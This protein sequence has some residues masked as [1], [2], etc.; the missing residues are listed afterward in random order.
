MGGGAAPAR[1]GAEASP[2]VGGGRSDPAAIAALRSRLAALGGLAA[3][4][5]PAAPRPRPSPRA[6]PAARAAALGFVEVEGTLLRRAR[7]DLT[8]FLSRA[9]APGPARPEDLVRLLFRLPAG[10]PAGPF[11]PSDLAVLDIETL[12]LRGSG[13]VP[14]LV[15]V[16]VPRGGELEIDQWLLA[17][18]E[19]EAA[20]LDA[21]AARLGGRRVLVTYNGR[22]FD[23]PVLQARCILNRRPPEA[24]QPPL[25][26]DLLGPVRRLFRD[27]L[28]SCTL[29]QAELSLLGLDRGDDLPGAEAPARFRAWLEGAPASVLEGVVRHNQLDLCATQVL[30]ARLAAHAAGDLIRPAHP[31]DRYRLGVHLESVG[32]ADAAAEHLTAAF[33]S[34]P[35]PWSRAAG[36]RLAAAL[37]RCGRGGESGDREAALIARARAEQVLRELWRR[38]PEDLEAARALAIVLERRGDL[39]AAL[40]V[41][42]EAERALAARTLWRTWQPPQPRPGRGADAA[43]GWGR[44]ATR[45]RRRIAAAA[46]SGVTLGI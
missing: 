7:V 27:R 9:G 26:C 32:L 11:G 38:D 39:G 5:G 2:S 30:A 28:G 15:G 45:L 33:A 42:T 36:H 24:L 29:R 4:A 1:T 14:F 37:R 3:L 17:D 40:G 34:A 23:V 19:A 13:V 6:A 10:A 12:G 46:V 31:A 21:V 8:P 43:G 44:R 25:H 18:L 41:C 22:G 16:G 20:M 35:S